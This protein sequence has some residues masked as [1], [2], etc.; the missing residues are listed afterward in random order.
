MRLGLP[1]ESKYDLDR[2]MYSP[3]DETEKKPDKKK[4]NGFIK[5]GKG[6]KGS[7]RDLLLTDRME[8]MLRR[9]SVI[10]HVRGPVIGFRLSA[11]LQGR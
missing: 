9:P 5:G 6:G 7:R 1:D 4:K 10:L 2:L 8:V 11:V 3:T